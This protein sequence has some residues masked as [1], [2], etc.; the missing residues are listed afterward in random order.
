METLPPETCDPRGL[1]GAIRRLVRFFYFPVFRKILP[2]QTFYYAACGA[3]TYY[4]IDP[5][6]YYTAYHYIF[7]KEILELGFVALSPH[8]A[9]LV[10]T[11]PIT[12]TVGFLLNRHVAF[13]HSP[14]SSGIQLFRY[15]VT[16]AGSLVFSYLLIK[17]FVDVCGFYPTPSKILSTTIIM[18][19]SYLA[20]KYFTF[21][22]SR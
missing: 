6:V 20:Q 22:G 9:A 12:F 19:Y 16:V 10:L 11:F 14:L 17:L 2:I 1:P 5:V 13:I 15:S 8:V 4:L 3:I 21:R 7:R 18:V